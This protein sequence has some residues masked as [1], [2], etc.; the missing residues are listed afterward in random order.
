M[1][2]TVILSKFSKK[3]KK[4]VK[5]WVG[6]ST[7]L[8]FF[9]VVFMLLSGDKVL[10]SGIGRTEKVR[11]G[12]SVVSV[13]VAMTKEAKSQGLSGRKSLA[14]DEGMLF[15]FEKPDKYHFWMKDMLFP[16]DII[17]IGEDFKVT[18]IQKGATPESY[19][20]IFG[21]EVDSMYVLEVEAGFS[22][23]NNLKVGDSLEFLR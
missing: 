13:D 11:V 19:P 21:G 10:T 22:E 12:E 3:N 4:S 23:K 14:S 5:F 15:V 1:V 7:I 17:W 8:L 9:G 20:Q 16:I 6:I 2:G 18:Y